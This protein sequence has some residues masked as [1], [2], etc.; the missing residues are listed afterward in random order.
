M[1]SNPIARAAAHIPRRTKI[2]ATVGPASWSSGVLEQMIDAGTDV[3]RLNFSHAGPAKQAETIETI[4]AA[5]QT[6]GREVAI[7]GDLPGPKLRI[8]EL[9]RRLRRAGDRHARH[10][11]P[12]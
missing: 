8:G 9:A 5:S 11:H 3:F 7:L 10:P 6:V 1:H 4:R 12:A 2:V